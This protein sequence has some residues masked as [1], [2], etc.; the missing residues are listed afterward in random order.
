MTEA[1]LVTELN[2][3]IASGVLKAGTLKYVEKIKALDGQLIEHQKTIEEL[4]GKIRAEETSI[5][6]LKGAI[7]AFLE[8]CGEEEGVLSAEAAKEVPVAPVTPAVPVV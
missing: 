1:E 5:I 3:R 8:L 6:R 2:K 4:S 7:A